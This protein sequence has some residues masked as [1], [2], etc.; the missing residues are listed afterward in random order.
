MSGEKIKLVRDTLTSLLGLL[1][2]NDR[3]CLIEFDDKS[4]RITPLLRVSKE[5]I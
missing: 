1:T 4:K 2:D 3:L 5:N